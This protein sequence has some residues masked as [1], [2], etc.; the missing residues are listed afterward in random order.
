[1]IP[2]PLPWESYW[3]SLFRLPGFGGAAV[4]MRRVILPDPSVSATA[5]LAVDIGMLSPQSFSR[6][7]GRPAP[8]GLADRLSAF[9]F[10]CAADDDPA[11]SVLS[12]VDD[13]LG[14]TIDITSSDP[15]TVGIRVTVGADLEESDPERGGLD[16]VTSRS[17]MAQA[18]IDV[19]FLDH[20]D[21]D[22]GGIHEPPVD[23]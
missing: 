4:F 22:F 3:P 13:G 7:L 12:F 2:A 11:S 14:L 18:A 8:L 1:M 19:R 23:W 20:V 10:S 15:T 9:F 17:V 6:Y 16:F 21:T 5:A